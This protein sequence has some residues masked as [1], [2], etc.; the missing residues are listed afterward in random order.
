M[1]WNLPVT[2]IPRRWPTGAVLARNDEAGHLAR[3][4][5]FVARNGKIP[6]AMSAAPQPAE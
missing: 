6:G 1:P 3:L 5:L 4:F 2:A